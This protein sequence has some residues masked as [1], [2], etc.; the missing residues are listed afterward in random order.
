MTNLTTLIP[1]IVNTIKAVETMLPNGTGKEKL[2][3]VIAT[4]EAIFG[5]LGEAMPAIT[6]FIGVVVGGFNMLGI[7]RKKA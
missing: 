5:A 6:N 2:D 7:F 1:L 4:I 3:A